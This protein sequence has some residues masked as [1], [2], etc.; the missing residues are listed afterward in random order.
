[1]GEN[2]DADTCMAV[3]AVGLT[4]G[5]DLEKLL[6]AGQGLR[7]EGIGMGEVKVEWGWVGRVRLCMC[8]QR[9]EAY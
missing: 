6:T 5:M 1:L 9:Q 2:P 7:I 3:C 8:L 4:S